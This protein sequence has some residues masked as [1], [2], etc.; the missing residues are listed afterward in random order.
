M[1]SNSLL[2]CYLAGSG[3]VK[4][5]K[6]PHLLGVNPAFSPNLPGHTVAAYVFQQAASLLAFSIGKIGSARKLHQ[7]RQAFASHTKT[8]A[9]SRIRAGCR[10]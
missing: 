1:L 10:R 9:D 3:G 6:N 5:G 8:N 4:F 2:K 7:W